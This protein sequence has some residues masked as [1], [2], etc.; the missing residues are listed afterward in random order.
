[1]VDITMIPWLHAK[2][3][4]EAARDRLKAAEMIGD[5][6]AIVAIVALILYFVSSQLSDS[7]FFT[8]GFGSLE[9]FFFYGAAILG[10][11]PSA[12]RLI[13]RRRNVVRPVE[14][15]NSI[16]GIV[17]IIYLLSVFPF[18]FA[19]LASPLPSIIQDAISWLT[20]DLARLLMT[21]GVVLTAFVT[22]WMVMIYLAVRRVLEGRTDT[23]PSENRG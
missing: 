5:V 14:I 21:F 18:D 17:A 20:N 23:G 12:F 13:L 6:F 10:I 8:D 19:H 11:F 2:A 4:K 9:A 1:M 22:A 3:K 7:G 15:G 16:F